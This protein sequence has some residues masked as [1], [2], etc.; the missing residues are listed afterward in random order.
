VNVKDW[1]PRYV[2]Y[3]KAHGRTPE[4]SLDG[5]IMTASELRL[6]ARALWEEAFALDE[7]GTMESAMAVLG[8]S[9][10]VWTTLTVREAR[11]LRRAVYP[12]ILAGR[13]I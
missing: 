8:R 7:H 13:G 4:E 12:T 2:E 3:A 9:V 5:S 11:A 10:W 6:A 1:N